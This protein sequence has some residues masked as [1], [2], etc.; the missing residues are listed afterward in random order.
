MSNVTLTLRSVTKTGKAIYE[1][2]GVSGS[3]AIRKS[4]LA[5]DAP[6]T[7]DL[8]TPREVFARHL[9][10]RQNA[11][12][13]TRVNAGLLDMLL[14]SSD[15]DSGFIC[16]SVDIEF[17]GPLEKLV[18]EDRFFGRGVYRRTH[19][20]VERLLIIDDRHRPAAKD[21]TRTHH[22]RITY[23]ICNEFS[24]IC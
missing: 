1:L 14:N 19:I 3:I 23:F 17:D 4:M 16:E 20:L 22:D 13:V 24:L 15:H 18:D 21:E 9:L 6:A 8:A 7:L 12:R 2:A 5:G 11:G 10:G